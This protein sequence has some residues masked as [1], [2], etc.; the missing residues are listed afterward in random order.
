MPYGRL[1]RAGAALVGQALPAAGAKVGV[2]RAET[3][4]FSRGSALRSW[5]A[6]RA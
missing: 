4:S 1:L 2:G 3:G 6:F 5:A